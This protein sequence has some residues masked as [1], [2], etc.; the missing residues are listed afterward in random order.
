MDTQYL[1]WPATIGHTCIQNLKAPACLRQ[2]RFFLQRKFRR[3]IAMRLNP[4]AI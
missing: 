3:L 2:V 1:A 4:V